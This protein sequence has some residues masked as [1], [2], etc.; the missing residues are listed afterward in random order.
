MPLVKR[1]GP[2]VCSAMNMLLLMLPG[3]PITYNG[4][5]IGMSDFEGQ[6]QYKKNA[7]VRDPCRTPMQWDDSPNAG[8]LLY[9]AMI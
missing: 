4:E 8:T 5:E 9:N 6:M 7:D 3:T 2:E 1:F